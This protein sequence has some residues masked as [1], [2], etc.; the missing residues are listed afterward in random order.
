MKDGLLKRRTKGDLDDRK[1]HFLDLHPLTE[2]DNPAASNSLSLCDSLISYAGNDIFFPPFQEE[3]T[4][5]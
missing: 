1:R 2:D 4:S 5:F 3:T